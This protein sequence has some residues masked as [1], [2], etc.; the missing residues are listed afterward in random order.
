MIVTKINELNMRRLI[1]EKTVEFEYRYFSTVV[2]VCV[3]YILGFTK[4]I[5]NAQY[6]QKFLLDNQTMKKI[7]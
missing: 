7:A 2:Y 4:E 3:A 5:E 6:L 1:D